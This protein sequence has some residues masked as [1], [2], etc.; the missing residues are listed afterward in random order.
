MSCLVPLAALSLGYLVPSRLS[1]SRHAGSRQFRSGAVMKV[2]TEVTEESW[3]DAINSVENLAVVEFYAPWCRTCRVVTPK[4]E[5]LA[6][7]LAAA[8]VKA[9]FFKV[10]FKANKDLCYKERVFALPTFHFYVPEIGRV[11]RFTATAGQL[12]GRLTGQLARFVDDPEEGGP[13]TLDRLKQVQRAVVEPVVMYK[14]MV[15]V[16]EG[17][18]SPAPEELLEKKTGVAR[19]LQSPARLER[20]EALFNRLDRDGNGMLDLGALETRTLTLTASLS[21]SLSLALSLSLS[22][23]LSLTL[24]LGELA[25]AVAALSSEAGTEAE[26]REGGVTQLLERIATD[27]GGADAVA[28]DKETFVGSVTSREVAQF[29]TPSDEFQAAFG[30]MDKD[31]DGTISKEELVGSVTRFCSL[32]SASC[33]EEDEDEFPQRLAEAFDAFDTDQSGELDY[34]EFVMMVSSRSP[35]DSDSDQLASEVTE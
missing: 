12:S 11:N 33:D 32:M 31:G 26:A 19:A 14:D 29:G 7:K 25:E 23:S 5:Q 17:L 30:G 24:T 4:Y 20:L 28:I 22:L 1:V 15:G 2:V 34:E 9:D 10:D 16:L 8:D 35:V 6:K 21:L 27:A 13:S 3:S 18:A